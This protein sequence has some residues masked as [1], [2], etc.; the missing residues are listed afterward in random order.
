MDKGV[1][2]MS[3]RQKAY[4]KDA[5]LPVKDWARRCADML[6]G[7]DEAPTLNELYEA[8]DE[9]R[10]RGWQAGAD[11][12]AMGFDEGF[13]SADDWITQNEDAMRD[14]GWIK[15]SRDRR[16]LVNEISWLHSELHGAEMEAKKAAE[17]KAENMR[18]RS[19]LEDAAEND[20]LT[21]HEFNQLK[22]ENAKLRELVGD[23]AEEYRLAAE[24]E[25]VFALKAGLFER[26][27]ELGVGGRAMSITDELREWVME[28]TTNNVFTC[29]PLKHEV[30][31]TKE[32]LLDIADRI[33]AEHERGMADAYLNGTPTDEQMAELGWVRLPKDADGELIRVGDAVKPFGYE[34][35]TVASVEIH[36]D[37]NAFVGVLPYGCDVPTVHNAVEVFHYRA[38]TVEDVL[39]EFALACEDA[40]NAGP[41]VARIAAGYAAKLKLAEEDA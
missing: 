26:M 15:D 5:L 29:Y 31:G 21:T 38:S 28:N 18:L 24:S 16:D 3:E 37:G 13:A 30:C 9:V 40:G 6:D 35:G 8:I 33:D 34:S 23:L 7:A 17:I 12:Y 32:R 36:D 19:C 4:G 20:R 1:D 25:G 27:R 14:H 41:E 10:E 39:R 11:A 22:E 2:V